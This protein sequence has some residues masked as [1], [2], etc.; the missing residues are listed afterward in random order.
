MYKADMTDCIEPYAVPS[1]PGRHIETMRY[2]ASSIYSNP[3]FLELLVSNPFWASSFRPSDHETI[4]NVGSRPRGNVT[5]CSAEQ[6]ARHQR[7]SPKVA[8]DP[9][10]PQAI[11][12]N[13]A[14]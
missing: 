6:D 9:S 14:F 4:R 11:N 13:V 1:G 2:L 10:T 3:E 7:D 12:S 5:H 8:R